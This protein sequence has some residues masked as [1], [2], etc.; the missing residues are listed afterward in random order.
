MKRPYLFRGSITLTCDGS[1]KTECIFDG[2]CDASGLGATLGVAARSHMQHVTS[3]LKDQ[4]FRA[5]LAAF[6]ASAVDATP[7]DVLD[8]NVEMLTLVEGSERPS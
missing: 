3:D 6:V 5:L 8:G 2:S 4:E 1:A 7:L